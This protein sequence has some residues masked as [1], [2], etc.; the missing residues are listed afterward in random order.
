MSNTKEE[1]IKDFDEKLARIVELDKREKIIKEK[2]LEIREH[3]VNHQHEQLVTTITEI[4]KAKTVD[5]SHVTAE[6]L[7]QMIKENDEY[8]E[9]AK[10]PLPFIN[11]DFNGIVPFFKKNLILIGGKTGEG[12][13][14]TVANVVVRL[15]MSKVN[16]KVPK[17]L[18]IVN[19]EK[20]EDVY[21]RITCFLRGWKYSDHHEF[22]DEQRAEFK[23]MIPIL[24]Q[25]IVVVSD[26]FEGVRGTTTTIE[27]ITG[28]FDD[29]IDNHKH[30]DAILFD[31]YQ[32]VTSSKNEPMLDEFKVQRKL[33]HL[34]NNYKNKLPAPL[35]LFAQINPP[36]DPENPSPFS[37]R[38][39]GTKMICDAATFI[40]EMIPERE[41][42]RTKWVVHKSRFTTAM[43]ERPTFYSG[44]D[45]GRYVEYDAAW[46]AK[47]TKA[48]N[49]RV[50][51]TMDKAIGILRGEKKEDENGNNDQGSG[52]TQTSG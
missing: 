34:L 42:L 5:Y 29:I 28:V 19:E 48:A 3:R 13:S 38:I 20:P 24:A 2:E 47:V 31:Y 17:I 50:H 44:F 9:A 36:Q 43:T 33:A 39:K 30:F 6:Y 32:N 27:G 18:I 16:G 12:K 46:I 1:K 35:V 49:D 15:L 40:M 25:A 45:K 4:Q 8:M 21:N 11:G 41:N 37:V 7:A 10:N 26:D 23:K 22:T 14:T 51:K 52:S